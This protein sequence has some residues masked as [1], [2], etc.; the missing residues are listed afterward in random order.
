MCKKKHIY[1]YKQ[2]VRDHHLSVRFHF[3]VLKMDISHEVIVEILHVSPSPHAMLKN[4][5][6]T[7]RNQQINKEQQQIVI[8][9]FTEKQ[10]HDPKPIGSRV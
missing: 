5:I 1:I 3:G 6:H 7:S 2:Q 4:N 9:L 8:F 10:T